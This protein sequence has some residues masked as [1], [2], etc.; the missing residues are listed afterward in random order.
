MR[1][2]PWDTEVLKILYIVY[3]KYFE[4]M[5]IRHL[6]LFTIIAE[7]TVCACKVPP[8]DLP[9]QKPNIILIMADD[10]GWFDA[11]FNGNKEILTPNMD[12]LASKGVI[13]DRFYSASAVCSPTR[14]SFITGR[15][16]F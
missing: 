8:E 12:M 9:A 3:R 10:L 2:F 14:A 7:V 13:F 6:L 16:S 1:L 11:G 15:R 4:F 5:T